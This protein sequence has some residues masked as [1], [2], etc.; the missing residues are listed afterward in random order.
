VLIME[1]RSLGLAV[2]VLSEE[3]KLSL[4]E[5]TGETLEV[6]AEL[7][8]ASDSTQNEMEGETLEAEAELEPAS[9]STQNEVTEDNA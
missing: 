4:P 7:K 8:P 3:E 6:E 2:E 9:D 5:Q 1:L